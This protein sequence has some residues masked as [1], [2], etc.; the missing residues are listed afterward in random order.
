LEAIET[1][2]HLKDLETSNMHDKKPV[3]E[4]KATSGNDTTHTWE[5]DG[6]DYVI[7]SGRSGD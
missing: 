3:N 1:D 5:N 7:S 6:Q 2:E 4:N